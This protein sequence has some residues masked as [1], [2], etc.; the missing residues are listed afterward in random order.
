MME[1]YKSLITSASWGVDPDVTLVIDVKVWILSP[2]LILSGEY[3]TKKSRLYIKPEALS[4]TGTQSSSVQPGYTVDSYITISFGFKRLPIISEA[5]S[6]GCR[7]GHLKRSMGVGTV[8]INT[9]HDFRSC[10]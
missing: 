8:T 10:M 5:F 7:S 1:A 9:E 4:N 3:P 2:G 6:K